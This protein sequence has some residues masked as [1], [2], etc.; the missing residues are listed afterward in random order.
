MP[1]RDA[2]LNMRQDD[3]HADKLKPSTQ[4]F[5]KASATCC[6]PGKLVAEAG[7]PGSASAAGAA[8]AAAAGARA[9]V[10]GAPAAAPEAAAASRRSIAPRA[11]GPRGRRRRSHRAPAQ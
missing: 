3:M 2:A 11:A 9:P 4:C 5:V 8:G 1:V 6:G 10:A 7:R